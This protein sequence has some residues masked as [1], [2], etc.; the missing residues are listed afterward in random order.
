MILACV[1]IPGHASDIS[2]R[3]SHP[4]VSKLSSTGTCNATVQPTQRGNTGFAFEMNKKEATGRQTEYLDQPRAYGA[5]C[6]GKK[7]NNEST[8]CGVKQVLWQGEYLT[9]LLVVSC[10]CKK[11]N[12]TLLTCQAVL[13]TQQEILVSMWAERTSGVTNGCWDIHLLLWAIREVWAEFQSHRG[14][15]YDHLATSRPQLRKAHQQAHEGRCFN[16]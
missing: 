9:L 13:I 1:V 7:K 12:F 2:M 11:Y 3:L 10:A 14:S 6:R 16:I 15:S 8:L 5:S 4:R